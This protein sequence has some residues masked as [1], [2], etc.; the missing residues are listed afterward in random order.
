MIILDPRQEPQS[1]ALRA[2]LRIAAPGGRCG[3][4]SAGLTSAAEQRAE[5]PTPVFLDF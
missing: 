5:S 2:L 4:T 3:P 1:F